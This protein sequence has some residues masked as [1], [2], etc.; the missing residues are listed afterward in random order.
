MTVIP[1]SLKSNL[2]GGIP[3]ACSDADCCPKIFIISVNTYFGQSASTYIVIQ[4]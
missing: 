2:K 3:Y 4:I 1:I